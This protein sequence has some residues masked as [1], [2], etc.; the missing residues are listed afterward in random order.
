MCEIDSMQF[1]TI[2]VFNK[3]YSKCSN[4]KQIN[5]DSHLIPD[6]KLKMTALN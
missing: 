6:T 1:N 4:G 2:G 3:W 5:V